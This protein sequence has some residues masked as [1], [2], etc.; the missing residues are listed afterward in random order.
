MTDDSV[1]ADGYVEG[2]GSV[3]EEIDRLKAELAAANSLVSKMADLNY[4]LGLREQ[5]LAAAQERVRELG[6]E[7]AKLREQVGTYSRDGTLFCKGCG[8]GLGDA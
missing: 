1:W 5:E 7:R 6:A 3:Q 8:T 2:R 4:L